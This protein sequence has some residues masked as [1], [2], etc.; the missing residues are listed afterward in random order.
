[1]KLESVGMHSIRVTLKDA[2]LVEIVEKGA[3]RFGEFYISSQDICVLWF[4]SS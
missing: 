2:K 4:D 3:Y 1:M